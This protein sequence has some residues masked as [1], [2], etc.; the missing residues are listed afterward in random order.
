MSSQYPPHICPI[1]DKPID[2]AQDR[3][4]NEDGRVIH[5]SCYIKRLMS[6]QNDPP[7]PNHAE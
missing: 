3:Y 4:A 2:L 7:D 5:E 1:C 6:G